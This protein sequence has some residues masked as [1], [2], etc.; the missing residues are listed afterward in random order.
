MGYGIIK[1]DLQGQWG[2]T[3]HREIVTEFKALLDSEEIEWSHK[4]YYFRDGEKIED[5]MPKYLVE[6]F[7]NEGRDDLQYNFRKGGSIKTRSHANAQ[8]ARIVRYFLG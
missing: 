8:H 1:T 7:E 2:S 3:F 6:D 5:V 4:I